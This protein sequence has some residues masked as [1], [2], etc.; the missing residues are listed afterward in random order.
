MDIFRQQSLDSYPFVSVDFGKPF[1]A[2]YLNL[3]HYF[4]ENAYSREC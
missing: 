1:L 2:S 4:F 3:E